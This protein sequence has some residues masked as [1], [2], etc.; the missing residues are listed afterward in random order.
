[1]A[2][3]EIGRFEATKHNDARRHKSG[4]TDSHRGGRGQAWLCVDT[5]PST[6]HAQVSWLHSE[7]DGG[8]TAAASNVT[9][10]LQPY[11]HGQN[12]DPERKAGG[13]AREHTV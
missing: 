1:M 9:T 6:G 2:P 11:D 7:Q 5:A 10:P 8:L 3:V 13:G 4:H 12:N